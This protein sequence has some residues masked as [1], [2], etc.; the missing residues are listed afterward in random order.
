VTPLVK[1]AVTPELSIAAG[2]G[3]H[4]LRPL[5]AGL[6]PDASAAN[7]AIGSLRYRQQWGARQEVSAAL[8]LRAGRRAL[9]SDFDYDRY[10][11]HV[12]YAL[13]RGSQ[14]VLI[15]GTAGRIGGVAPLFERFSLGDAHTLRGWDK[16]T[17]APLGGTRMAHGSLE[18]RVN[19]IQVFVDAGS[20]WDAGAARRVRVSTGLG[21]AHGPAF[22]TV[23]FPLNGGDTG[24]VLLTGF[25]IGFSA[26]GISRH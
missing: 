10:V 3:I 12:S 22:F 21:V 8:T 25:R 5:D 1:F 19:A 13:H 2:V 26:A 17:I 4:E 9:E 7:V 15:S 6:I 20:V 24:A 23:A 18:Y 16:F 14:Q 11:G